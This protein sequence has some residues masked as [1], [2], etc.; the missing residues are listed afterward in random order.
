M[1]NELHNIRRLL[2]CPSPEN[3]RIANAELRKLPPAVN[4][5]A[6][7]FLAQKTFTQDDVK[8]LMGLRSEILSILVLLTSALDYFTRLRLL[9]APGFGDYERSGELRPLEMASRTIGQL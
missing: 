5:L 1:L 6:R 4:E 8:S 2:T 3:V 7:R 9:R